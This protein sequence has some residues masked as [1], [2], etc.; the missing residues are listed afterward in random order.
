VIK[1]LELQ[2]ITTLY[3]NL[4]VPRQNV[5]RQNVRRQ[6]VRGQNVRGDKTS[7]GT[8]RP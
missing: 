3:N 5:R 4:M 2:I 6:D 7:V 1:K 8:K